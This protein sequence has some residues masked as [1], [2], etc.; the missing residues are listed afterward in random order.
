MRNDALALLDDGTVRA[1]GQNRQGQL[2]DG[3]DGNYHY[4]ATPVV[5]A[6]L[7]GV[8]ALAAGNGHSLAIGN[9][10]PPPGL[11]Q[12]IQL[13]P[14][15]AHLATGARHTITATVKDSRGNPVADRPVTLLV[16]DGPDA[17][18]GGT[19]A[20]AADGSVF[21]TYINSGRGMDTIDASFADSQGRVV[22][23]APAYA[24][25]T[26]QEHIELLPKEGATHNFMILTNVTAEIND[27]LGIP[28]FGRA[29]EFEVTG[30]PA[31]VGMKYRGRTN[32]FGLADFTVPVI[33]K[34]TYTLI[35]R[36]VDNQGNTIPSNE[37]KIKFAKNA[38]RFTEEEK[39]N[40]KRLESV[41]FVGTIV[42]G[43]A[44]LTC[45][46]TGPGAVICT[47]VMWGLATTFAIE[48]FGWMRLADDPPDPNFRVIARPITPSLAMQP[49]AASDGLSPRQASA[50]NAL[51][52]NKEQC[53]G[54][55]EAILVAINRAQG[56]HEAGDSG[57]EIRQ[58]DAARSYALQLVA[59][60]R[61]QPALLA[62]LSASAQE[63]G[64]PSAITA[65]D[66]K[67]FQTEVSLN[68]LPVQ[69]QQMLRELGASDADLETYRLSLLKQD[70]SANVPLG[71]GNVFRALSDPAILADIT[72]SAAALD[73]FAASTTLSVTAAQGGR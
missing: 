27:D 65:D 12:S 22:H 10:S 7:T 39:A 24:Y 72:E 38:P 20:T 3:T 73:T 55:A 59:L 25:F 62:E 43:A 51:L 50:L 21:L 69:L 9:A 52:S 42:V 54:I 66:I 28:V 41:S 34:G 56:A 35:A 70:E 19:I 33:G 60:T 1:W 16:T 6:G 53:S 17:G 40:F 57:G 31:S 32:Q 36:F 26:G 49:V 4:H 67:Q 64:F 46:G 44:G 30:G 13:S 18:Q 63:A 5:V 48:G 11:S 14:A 8:T 71:E 29:V 23:A 45:T 68:G 61:V 37:T 58:M 47:R 15:S 2:G